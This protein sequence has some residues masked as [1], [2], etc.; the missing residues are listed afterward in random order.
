MKKCVLAYLLAI[1]VAGGCRNDESV[2]V[3][4]PT[5]ENLYDAIKWLSDD[6]I[7]AVFFQTYP[8]DIPRALAT[9]HE[10]AVGKR[11]F[12]WYHFYFKDGQWHTGEERLMDIYR[13]DNGEM[14][15][16]TI[17]PSS[18]VETDRDAF[19]YLAEEGQEPKFIV[20]DVYGKF[21]SGVYVS[22][23]TSHI[24][25]DEEGYLKRIPIPQLS[26]KDWTFSDDEFDRDAFPRIP[27]KPPYYKL[28][29]LKLLT[30]GPNGLI[31]TED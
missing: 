21:S 7:Y 10:N 29:R 9:S 3:A 25:I 4:Q 14:L 17:D 26:F 22:Q 23:E 15:G 5:V 6:R 11:S 24:I 27:L 16:A 18:Y 8:D 31:P 20:A 30:F 13:D 19:F 12:H 1:G 2:A 28:E